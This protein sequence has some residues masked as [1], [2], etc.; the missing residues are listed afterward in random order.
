MTSGDTLGELIERVRQLE[1]RL[2]I[3][4]LGV[5]YCVAIDDGDYARLVEMYTEKAT[6][7][8]TVG[9][10]EVV[11]LLRT[12]RAD[13]GRTIHIPEAHSISFTDADHATGL[14]L[15]HAELDIQDTTVH[16]FIR[17][18]DEYERGEDGAWRFAN[19]TLKFAYAVPFEQMPESLTGVDTVRWPGTSP[20]PADVF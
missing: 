12:I 16:T 6:M 15:S 19:R 17:Y 10:Q 5:R 14:V 9:R 7:G 1:D 11:D 18:Y 4:D 20:A 8:E 13:Y 3:Q 2:A